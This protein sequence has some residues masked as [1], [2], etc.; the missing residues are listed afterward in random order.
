MK[1]K[2][3]GKNLPETKEVRCPHCFA[4]WTPSE[5]EKKNAKKEDKQ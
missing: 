3:C 5:E 2:F 4:V 1:C